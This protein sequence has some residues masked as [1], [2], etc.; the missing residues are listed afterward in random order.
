MTTTSIGPDKTLDPAT[1]AACVPL[2]RVGTQEVGRQDLIMLKILTNVAGYSWN[3]LVSRKP[4]S[5]I[6]EW[7]SVACGWG[8]GGQCRKQW[9]S[10]LS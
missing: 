3:N 5:C 1:L 6:R 4:S 2:K 8:T 10:E 9:L 7:S